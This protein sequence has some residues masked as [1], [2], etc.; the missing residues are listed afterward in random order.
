MDIKQIL[1]KLIEGVD[2]TFEEAE[3]VIDLIALGELTP[4]QIAAFLT[5][6]K[7]KGESTEEVAGLISGMRRHMLRLENSEGAMDIVGSGGD[8]MGTFN[9][10]TAS[11]L[12]VAGAGVKVAKHGNR[13]ASSKCGSADVLEELG[14]NINL[15]APQAQK[16][17][18]DCGIV[19]LF[20]PLYH[21]A[22]KL[23][24]PV[25]RE[26]GFRTVINF[27]GPFLNPAGVKR[28][29]MGLPN[30]KIAKKLSKVAAKLGYE[31]LLMV[32]GGEGI[33][34]IGLVGKTHG[35]EIKGKK[36]KRIIIDP[37]ALGFYKAETIHL[38]G[39]EAKENARIIRAILNGEKGP[40]RDIVLLNSAF[41]LKVSGKVKNIKDGLKLAADSIDKGAAK[42]LLKALIQESRK[43]A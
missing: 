38:I 40:K 19:F 10:S 4:S 32:V 26:L 22:M 30:L 18:E 39:G 25:R 1:N 20:A 7:I 41:S 43:Y 11:A 2:L 17:L 16:V 8:G 28:T 24:A 42:R 33:D 14:V 13:A 3:G 9:I 5:G 15:T 34:E 35:F 6:L 23:I 21:P 37:K 12:V 29:L 31:Y 27:L 36:L